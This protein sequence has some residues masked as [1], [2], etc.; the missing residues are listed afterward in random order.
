[1]GAKISPTIERPFEELVEMTGPR[2]SETIST[3][4]NRYGLE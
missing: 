4:A 1:L 2:T 3:I